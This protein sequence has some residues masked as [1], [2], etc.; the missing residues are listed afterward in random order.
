VIV[1]YLR[2]RGSPCPRSQELSQVPEPI[3]QRR[4]VSH[5]SIRREHGLQDAGGRV[6]PFPHPREE[7]STVRTVGKDGDGAVCEDSRKN[8]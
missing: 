5:A 6:S 2:L 4:C 7:G 3:G 8:G 1:G